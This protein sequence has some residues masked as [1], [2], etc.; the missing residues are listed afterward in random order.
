M[1]YKNNRN[2]AGGN[3]FNNNN[4]NYGNDAPASIPYLIPAPVSQTNNY[5][6]S[7]NNNNGTNPLNEGELYGNDGTNGI[8]GLG[9]DLYSN[10]R[11]GFIRKVYTLVTLQLLVTAGIGYWGYHSVWFKKTFANLVSVIVLSVLL[12]TISCFIAC[13][14]TT[15]RKYALPLFIIFTLLISILVAIS[16]SAYKSSVVMLAVGITL[17]LVIAL[18]IYACMFL[19]Y[20]GCTKTDFTGCGPY[21]MMILMVLITFGIVAIFWPNPILQLVY[22]CLGALVFS[23][24]LV[25]DTQLILGKGQYSYSLDD[26]YL[27]AIQL[28]LDVINLFLNILAIVGGGN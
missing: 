18:T 15:F 26:A 21:L 13:C 17:L 2:S 25:Y 16:I 28:Y 1:N 9:N 23:I 24:F 27:A 8:S 14:M 10:S 19:S 4:N 6:Y 5:N 22:S 11:I 3:Y 20:L 7:N 12:V